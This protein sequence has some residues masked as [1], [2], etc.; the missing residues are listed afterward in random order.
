[1]AGGARYGRCQAD[2]DL[3]AK[4]GQ[5]RLFLFGY[6]VGHGQHGVA[7]LYGRKHGNRRAGVSRSV[8]NDSA[9]GFQLR[10]LFGIFG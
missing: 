2:D 8:F 3:R 1:M 9:A 6:L 7:A 10:G 5:G 4:R